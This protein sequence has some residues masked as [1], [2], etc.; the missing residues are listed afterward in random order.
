MEFVVRKVLNLS[1]VSL[2]SV[3]LEL[4]LKIWCLAVSQPFFIHSWM[5]WNSGHAR[6]PDQ[7]YYQP[8][9]SL[10]FIYSS[11]FIPYSPSCSVVVV[12]EIWSLLWQLP[13]LQLVG[14]V[15]NQG[16]FASVIHSG[17]YTFQVVHPQFWARIK[18]LET[19]HL[20]ITSSSSITSSFYQIRQF[21]LPAYTLFYQ[22]NRL[23]R[24]L[25]SLLLHLFF[26]QN[27]SYLEQISNINHIHNNTVFQSSRPSFNQSLRNWIPS[28]LPLYFVVCF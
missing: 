14:C 17:R 15:T 9:W 6:C 19:G 25:P 18:W 21:I 2:N 8:F 26:V 13:I 5:C 20:Y 7:C 11:M 4:P 16:N 24:M 28:S 22:N 27:F 3:S 1:V 23:F 10:L 12:I